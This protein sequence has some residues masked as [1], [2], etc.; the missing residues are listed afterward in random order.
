[1]GELSSAFLCLLKGTFTHCL[2]KCVSVWQASDL[3]D[4]CFFSFSVLLTVT[5]LNFQISGIDER[6]WIRSGLGKM[7]LHLHISEN[8][9]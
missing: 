9:R 5:I 3:S 6:T 8:H 7:T 1:M 2:C 4:W